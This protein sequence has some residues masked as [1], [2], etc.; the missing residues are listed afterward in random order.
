MTWTAYWSDQPMFWFTAWRGWT[1]TTA[2]VPV[3]RLRP[4]T[5]TSICWLALGGTVTEVAV[6]FPSPGTTACA[7]TWP[8]CGPSEETRTSCASTVVLA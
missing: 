2:G 8:A 1:S 4:L 6:T 5:T 3:V 7:S